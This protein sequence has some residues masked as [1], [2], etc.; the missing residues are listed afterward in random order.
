[1]GWGG[2][3]RVQSYGGRGFSPTPNRTICGA[4]PL[5][6]NILGFLKEVELQKGS[7]GDVIRFR[8]FR[9]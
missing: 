5:G 6:L 4:T 3:G 2:G 1:M 9:F 7:L 8:V